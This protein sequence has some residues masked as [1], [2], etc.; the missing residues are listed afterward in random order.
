MQFT[1]HDSDRIP[2]QDKRR[3]LY[4]VFIARYVIGLLIYLYLNLPTVATAAEAVVGTTCTTLSQTNAADYDTIA[5]CSG[6]TFIRQPYILGSTV[7]TC[8][9]SHGG[10]MQWTGSAV[11][12]CNGSSWITFGAGTAST[13]LSGL[14]AAAATNS[15]DNATYAQTWTW[16]TETTT[17]GFTLT[18]TTATSGSLLT[19][20]N[21]NTAASTGAVLNVSTSTVGTGKGLVATAS[22]ASNTSYA[23]YFSNSSATGYGIYSAGTSPNYFGGNINLASG[24]TYQIN[25]TTVLTLPANDTTSIA[26]GSSA[27]NSQSSTNQYN[28]AAG[29]FALQATTVGT[30]NTAV[31]Y[32]AAYSNVSGNYLSAFGSQALYSA[33]AGPNDAFGYQAGYN[34]TSG[35]YNVALGD[36]AMYGSA[37]ITGVDNTAAGYQA[38]YNISGAAS[39]NTA[40]GA[41]AL[42]TTTTAN[43]LTA[44]G[45]QALYSVTASPND[46]LGCNAGQSITTGTSNVAVGF[47]AIGIGTTTGSYNTAIG[48]YSS[49]FL[50]SGSGNTAVG[51]QAFYIPYSG[52]YNTGVGASAGAIYTNSSNMTAFGYN[53]LSIDDAASASDAFGY[54]AGAYIS[55]GTSNV[56][57]GYEALYGASGAFTN[58]AYN[59]AVGYKALTLV[60]GAGNSNTALGYQAGDAGTAITTGSTDTFVGWD[61]QANSAT[62]TNGTAIGN[63]AILTGSSYFVL[64]NSSVTALYAQVTSI[65]T[66]S[67]RRL[68]KDITNL[69]SELGLTFI[70]KLKPVSYRFNSGDETERYGFIAQELKKALPKP[71]QNI[72]ETSNPEHGLAL[73]ERENNDARTYRVSYGELTAPIIKALQEQETTID[74][75]HN[76]A[77][78]LVHE[79]KP[80]LKVKIQK[81]SERLESV[82]HELSILS[83]VISF[84]GII[85]GFWLGR[86]KMRF[87]K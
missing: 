45:Y 28:T 8:D 17:V 18:S 78:T 86:L 29:A 79:S 32:E 12:Y 52:S 50:S 43:N 31:G 64:G 6:V 71:L 59:T 20:T 73:I 4:L 35:T 22:G 15:F 51:E 57:F 27:L 75:D 69:T 68:K 55:T 48:A 66:I 47:D 74:Q 37:A 83:G 65:T 19:L 56:A 61:A 2:E 34:I 67:D 62:Y 76:Q 13:A 72:V 26:L 36:Q 7:D 58:G 39:N 54:E 10:M 5:A 80:Y 87:N 77:I 70:G 3:G 84:F 1:L 53:A 33:T 85:L 63:A 42:Y 38:L 41:K 49:S 24:K 82:N 60:Q 21:S 14:T 44:V 40:I 11:Q 30:S 23:G 9:S 25:G 16:N 81:L 46:A